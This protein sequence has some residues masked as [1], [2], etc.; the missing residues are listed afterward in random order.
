MRDPLVSLWPEGVIPVR[1]VTPVK[2]RAVSDGPQPLVGRPQSVVSPAAGWRL[3]Y[4][5]VLVRDFNV[6]ALRALLAKIEGRAQPIYVGPYDYAYGP[7]KRAGATNP[8]TS[9]FSDGTIFSD[10]TRWETSIYDC[11]LAAD[12]A[13]GATQISVTN[14]VTAPL[15][16]GD[17]FELDGRLHVIEEIVG[18]MWTIWPDLRADHASGTV[19]EIADPRMKAYLETKDAAAAAQMQYG[20]WGEITL[21]FVEAGW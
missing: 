11:T 17:Y 15:K 20:R 16:G 14:S 8:I 21:D 9:T 3:I 2:E 19:L 7:V 4:T 1:H 5:G 18:G 13:Q 12:A 6:H 10:G